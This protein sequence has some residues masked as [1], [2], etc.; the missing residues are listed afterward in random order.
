MKLILSDKFYLNGLEP[1]LF[2][3]MSVC[4]N[5]CINV[6]TAAIRDLSRVWS[7]MILEIQTEFIDFRNSK[8][9][10]GKYYS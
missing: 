1:V 4:Q 6:P 7:F 3:V 9:K 5:L 10:L 2:D 8:K